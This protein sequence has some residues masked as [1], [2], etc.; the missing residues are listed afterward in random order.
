LPPEL[1]EWVAEE[2]DFD[3]LVDD[4]QVP[5]Q[6]T[7]SKTE[8]E[9]GGLPSISLPQAETPPLIKPESNLHSHT[10]GGQAPS[11]QSV[12][13]QALGGQAPKAPPLADG[14]AIKVPTPLGIAQSAESSESLVPDSLSPAPLDKPATP[15]PSPSS[16]TPNP[17]DS[18]SGFPSIPLPSGS[19]VSTKN[20]DLGALPLL[21]T[22]LPESAASSGQSTSSEQKT[23]EPFAT[24]REKALKQ[25]N[26]G[27]LKEAL[28]LLTQYYHNPEMTHKE[29][30]DLLEI[31]DAL[32]REVIYSPRHLVQ[33][34]FSV[35]ASH[36][37]VSIAAQ[38]NVTPELLKSIN[39]L[40]DSQALTQGQQLKV[41]EGPFR[42]EVDLTLGEM[43]LFLK[44]MYACRFPIAVGTDFNSKVGSFEVS[45]KRTDRTYYGVGGKVINAADPSNP[46]GG[47]WIDLGGN[48]IHGSPEM[49]ATDLKSAGC[50]S[51]APIDAADAFIMLT[52]G[53]QVEFR[54]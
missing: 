53:S 44:D 29:Y 3:S 37:L 27:K 47:Y 42:G 39:Q 34:A 8:T 46:Y 32:A 10:L 28:V 52:L 51:L 12:G 49:A 24:A 35:G 22:P 11:G 14:P 26:E 21:D 15:L 25:A 4:I 23:L 33:P 48:C 45:D 6:N 31:L 18:I 17:S 50:I 7:K 36:T 1:A 13:G 40:G 19:L 43:T 2:P 20:S 9:M 54:K 5:D 16:T 38:Y 30:E 41:I